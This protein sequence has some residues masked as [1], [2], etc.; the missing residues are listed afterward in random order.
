M[1]RNNDLILLEQAYNKVRSNQRIIEAEAAAPAAGA[2][3]ADGAA[4][5]T[6][7]TAE[8]KQGAEVLQA[9]FKHYQKF[10]EVLQ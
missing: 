2:A 8:D 1:K 9:L 6:P 3:P 10:L 5:E 7:L 4:P